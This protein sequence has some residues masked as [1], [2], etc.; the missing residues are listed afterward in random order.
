MRGVSEP[1]TTS[2]WRALLDLIRPDA[3][4]FGFLAA[5]LAAAGTLPV[6]GPLLVRQI[7]DRAAEGIESGIAPA[8]REIVVP[9]AAFL[10]VAIA[11]QIARVFVA[12]LATNTAWTTANRLRVE[13][14]EHVLGLDH[15]FHRRHAPGELVQ[16]IDGDIT[17]VSDF[18]GR[19]LLKT[20]GTLMILAGMVVVVVWID[21]R[22]GLGFIVYMLIAGRLAIAVRDRSIEETVAHMGAE[23][24]LF[25][26]I[27]ERLVAS[28]D[29]RANGA[30]GHAMRR[31]VAEAT[32]ALGAI[33]RME[34]A[35]LGLWWMLQGSLATGL[36][37][38]LVASAFFIERDIISIGTAFLFLQYSIALRRPLEEIV[39]QFDVVQKANGAMVRV[40]EMKRL[41]TA[42][43]EPEP[44][45]VQQPQPATGS[46]GVTFDDV[47]FDY[48]D[49]QPVI[50]SLSLDIAPGTS[51]GIVGRTG[52]GKTTL[53]RLVLRLVDPS[54]GAVR[55]G[56]VDLALV[57]G[58]ER[59]RRVALVPQEVNLFG[60][61]VRDNLTFFDPA[62]D[63]ER[64]RTVLAEVGL[65][66]LD[67]DHEVASSGAGLSAGQ[68]QLLALA[69]V[70]LRDPDVVVL[71]EA[72]S[73]VDP[74]TEHRLQDAIERLLEG[75][76]ALVIA[77]RLS[78]LRFVDRI[79]VVDD[80]RIAEE[81]DR[82][83]LEAD[84]GSEFRRLLELAL[85]VAP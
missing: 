11:S 26:G 66:E 48:G 61:T 71:D 22:L 53:S 65:H 81:G 2:H 49:D 17:A 3:R 72:T 30:G 20:G 35:F 36:V 43:V 18:L 12:W 45:A 84:E 74:D 31:F 67:L 4:R 63:D 8:N 34:R 79:V 76:T 69:R 16:R 80:G 57:S 33:K 25:G 77:H 10:A 19:V 5:A 1:S 13:L 39:D 9:A 64:A 55:L 42:I 52:S 59:R 78:T 32:G 15:A 41:T 73:R 75:R 44:G 70:W 58:R 7:I 51:V 68:A 23:A 40:A 29:L 6:L 60:G 50:R 56:G 47:S 38:A 27:E 37:L 21:W 54:Q 82:A 62:I 83:L 28:E 24:Q 46:L 14:T 85:E